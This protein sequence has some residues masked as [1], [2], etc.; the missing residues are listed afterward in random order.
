MV[1]S[2]GNIIERKVVVSVLSKSMMERHPLAFDWS[3][4]KNE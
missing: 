3:L 2:I 1:K 4:Q